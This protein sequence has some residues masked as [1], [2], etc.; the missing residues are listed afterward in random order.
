MGKAHCWRLCIIQHYKCL[1]KQ[2]TPNSQS[3]R[4]LIRG[5]H[6]NSDSPCLLSTLCFDV[7]DGLTFACIGRRLLAL[8][9]CASHWSDRWDS[10]ESKTTARAFGPNFALLARKRT[11][12]VK[13]H[14]LRI[15]CKQVRGSTSELNAAEMIRRFTVYLTKFKYFVNKYK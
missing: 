7:L 4:N 6:S 11:Q 14:C 12:V 3:F 1:N 8:P 10:E 5:K 13:S 2:A 15:D 9:K